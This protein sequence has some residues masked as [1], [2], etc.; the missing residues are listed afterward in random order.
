[1]L[2]PSPSTRMDGWMAEHA[3]NHIQTFKDTLGEK[4]LGDSS[5]F[6]HNAS[7]ARRI[8]FILWDFCTDRVRL[9]VRGIILS[10]PAC[11]ISTWENRR[12]CARNR[13]CRDDSPPE[14]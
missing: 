4:R 10:Q 12:S 13:F 11:D 1:M 14:P 6:S 8:S 3:M 7:R 2:S 5:I 9:R